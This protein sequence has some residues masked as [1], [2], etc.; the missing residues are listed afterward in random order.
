[1]NTGQLKNWSERQQVLA[2][3]LIAGAVIFAL[4]LFI[5][6][7]L[8]RKRKEL[9]AKVEV[10]RSNLDR[11][12]YLLDNRVLEERMRHEEQKYRSLHNDWISTVAR[13][14]AFPGSDEM[15]TAH[16]NH[17]DFKVALLDVRQRLSR[18]SARLG[19]KLPQDLGIDESVHSTE[20]ARKRLLQLRTVEQLSDLVLGLGIKELKEIE[21]LRSIEHKEKT[22][23]VVFLEEYPVRVKFRGNLDC[24]FSLFRAVYEEEHVFALRHI[25]IEA[26]RGDKTELISI[27]AVM[28]SLV[29][30]SDQDQ[31]IPAPPPIKKRY[32]SPLGH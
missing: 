29:F 17:I 12:G 31:L 5:L 3:I 2:I 28:S 7:P 9:E 30:S 20:N 14:D 16:I 10:M 26:E 24:L 13:L 32:R 19:I 22:T 6:T 21:P 15:R 25:R 23:G 11:G 18:K 4:G 8:N 27:V 1:M